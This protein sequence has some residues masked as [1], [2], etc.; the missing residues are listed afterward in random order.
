M[1]RGKKNAKWRGVGGGGFWMKKNKIQ[2]TNRIRV[3]DG[4]THKILTKEHKRM[5]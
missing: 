2:K 5:S 3:S 1:W 4:I